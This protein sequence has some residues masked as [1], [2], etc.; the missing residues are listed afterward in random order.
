M[1]RRLRAVV[2]AYHEIGCIGIDALL[3]HG[4]DVCAVFTHV[5]RPGEN[6]WFQSVA[7]LSAKSNL[8]VFAPEKVDH[9]LWLEK[10]R[11]LQPDALFSFYYRNLVSEE[12]L[13]IPTA[14]AYNLHGSLLPKYRGR[15][16]ANWAILNGETETG[17]TLHHMTARPDAGDIVCQHRVAIDPQDD[18][19]TLNLKLAAAAGPLLDECLPLIRE[20][21]APRRP[22][23]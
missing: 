8:P 7:E 9:P 21:T 4:F 2:L 16:P 17:V 6:V 20:G 23:M 15:A 1:T 13:A 14:G 3:R 18:A 5:D 22:Q 10:I 11:A 19:R 12:L